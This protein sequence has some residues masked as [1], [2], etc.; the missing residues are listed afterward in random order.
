MNENLNNYCK[1]I[2]A[3]LQEL[4]DLG[5]LSQKG[6]L[7]DE[8]IAQA[9]AQGIIMKLVPVLTLK[10][11]ITLYPRKGDER[12][13]IA[14]GSQMIVMFG[15]RRKG[16]RWYDCFAGDQFEVIKLYGNQNI[17]EHKWPID[18]PLEALYA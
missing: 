1:N 9:E 14:A 11:P 18:L 3:D 13:T 16:L 17:V 7:T 4:K 2:T 8:G 6:F 5:Y 15:G 10:Y 12:V